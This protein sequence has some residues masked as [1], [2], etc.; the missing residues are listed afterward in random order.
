MTKPYETVVPA[1]LDEVNLLDAGLQN[2]PYHAYQMLRDDAPVW[3]DPITGFYVI[4][5]FEDMRQVLLDTKNF[6][7]DMR[8]GQ[9][10]SREQLDSDRAARMMKLYEDKGW[11]PGADRKS[12]V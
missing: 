1:S 4:S 2:C 5:R 8:G 10:G 3:I 12:V 6:S 11:V 9:G 7:N